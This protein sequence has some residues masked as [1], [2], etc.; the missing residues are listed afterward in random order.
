MKSMISAF[1]I[2]TGGVLSLAPA[3]ANAADGT[4]TISGT[5]TDT[6]CSINGS[7][8]GTP[9]DLLVTLPSVP[10]SALTTSG[11]VAG[12]SNAADLRF[13]LTGCTG[14]ATKAIA[15]FENGQTIDQSTG[16]LANQGG[17]AKN[18]EVQL[19]NAQMQPINVLTGRN[20]DIST[21]GVAITGGAATL[22]YF[23]QYYALDA[24]QAG[25]VYTSVQYTMQYQ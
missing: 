8:S 9:A 13:V 25:T 22:Q 19:L 20:N 2:A 10:A 24:A 12:T 11:A 15:N 7:A 16:L 18:V 5:V 14:A 4:I 6:T 23:A 17:T 21:S 1:V 3:G